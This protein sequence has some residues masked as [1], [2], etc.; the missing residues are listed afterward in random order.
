MKNS[1]KGISTVARGKS[2][3]SVDFYRSATKISEPEIER[4]SLAMLRSKMHDYEL[5]HHE[6]IA[7]TIG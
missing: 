7:R 3:K 4:S 5:S 6:E 2:G 1:R